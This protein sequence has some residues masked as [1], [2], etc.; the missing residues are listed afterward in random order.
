[1]IKG[2]AILAHRSCEVASDGVQRCIRPL[3]SGDLHHT[4]HYILFLLVDDMISPAHDSSVRD[5]LLMTL[6]SLTSPQHD[7]VDFAVTG[8]IYV[9]NVGAAWLWFGTIVN[10]CG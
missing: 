1:L 5:V 9:G 7:L 6:A 8:S 4:T 3:A 2:E 10:R